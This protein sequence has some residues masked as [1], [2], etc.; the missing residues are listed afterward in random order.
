MTAPIVSAKLSVNQRQRLAGLAD[1][2][3]AGGAGLPSASAADVHGMWID[4]ALAARPDL[5]PIVL[6][7]IDEKGGP[8]DVLDGL[9]ERDRPKFNAFAFAISGAYLINPQ[10]RQLLGFPGPIPAKNPAFPDEAQSYLEDGLL[11]PVINRGP[12]YRRTPPD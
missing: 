12:I 5:L 7:V 9:C 2:L 1:R 11:D 3:I 10:I 4:R 6:E 8:G